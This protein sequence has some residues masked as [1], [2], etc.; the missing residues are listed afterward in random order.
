MQMHAISDL[1]CYICCAFLF[2][3][4]LKTTLR[5]DAHS[6]IKYMLVCIMPWSGARHVIQMVSYF[7]PTIRRLMVTPFYPRK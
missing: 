4:N 5:C 3:K 2:L 1:V 6:S 7:R